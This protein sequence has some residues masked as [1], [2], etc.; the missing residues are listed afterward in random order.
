MVHNENIFQGKKFI[1]GIDDTDNRYSRGTGH[2]ARK[3]GA[4]IT[5]RKLGNLCSISRHQ[6]LVDE[7]IPYTSH[8]SSASIVIDQVTD[9]EKL[10]FFCKKFL[11]WHSAIGSDTGL[12]IVE[13]SKIG[14]EIIDWGIRAKTEVLNKNQAHSLAESQKILLKGLRGEKIG[15][16][17][18]LAAVGLNAGGNDGRLLWLPGMRETEGIFSVEKIQQNLH[19]DEICTLKNDILASE[20]KVYIG[21]WSR[22]V[23]INKK[24]TLFVEEVKNNEQFQWQSASKEFIKSISQ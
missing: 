17:G 16:I 5:K 7:R 10:I 22:P 23:N 9:T 3:L 11:W 18:S 12:C 15:V 20:T 1:I 4:L 13:S 21:L 14:K 19:I 2:R 24:I 6:L 8:N